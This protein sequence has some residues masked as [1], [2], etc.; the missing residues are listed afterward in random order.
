MRGSVAFPNDSRSYDA[1]RLAVR[2]W[3][4]DQSIEVPFFIGADVLGALQPAMAAAPDGCLAA[5]DANCRA[6]DVPNLFVADGAPF[7][8]QADKNPTWSIMAL[9]WRTSDHIMALRKQGA[10]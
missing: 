7:P 10:V 2:F 8:S 6:H 3:G 5:F 1:T 9:A 4:Y